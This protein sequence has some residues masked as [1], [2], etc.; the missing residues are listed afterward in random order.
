[1]TREELANFINS[2]DKEE[3]TLFFKSHGVKKF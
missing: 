2:V 1:M 3:F